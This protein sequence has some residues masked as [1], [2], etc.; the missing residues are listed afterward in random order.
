LLFN[1]KWD[2][3]ETKEKDE[4]KRQMLFGFA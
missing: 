2:P 4:N 3:V 1:L